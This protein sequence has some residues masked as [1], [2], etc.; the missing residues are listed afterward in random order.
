M[1]TNRISKAMIFSRTSIS[2]SVKKRLRIIRI[3]I[4][5]SMSMIMS[6]KI[7]LIINNSSRMSIVN[8]RLLKLDRMMK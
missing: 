4:M 2:R 8:N 1:K 7:Y 5:N 6:H 3:M